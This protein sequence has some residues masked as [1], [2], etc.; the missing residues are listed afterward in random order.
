MKYWLE[1]EV[2]IKQALASK[3][4]KINWLALS[5]KHLA[6]LNWLQ[7]ERLIYL[8]I[9][10]SFCFFSLS[11]FLA[12]LIISQIELVVLTLIFLVTAIFY[13]ICYYLLENM[14]RRWHKLNDKLAEKLK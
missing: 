3:K 8:L 11:S 4:N 5:E 10:L 1:H 6:K 13:I 7:H 12:L 2:L 9:A 14:V